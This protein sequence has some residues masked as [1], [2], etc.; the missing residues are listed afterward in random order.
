[1][2][3]SFGDQLIEIIS[4]K[5]TTVNIRGQAK[6]KGKPGRKGKETS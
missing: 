1:M 3:D 5:E 2:G 6:M 4:P